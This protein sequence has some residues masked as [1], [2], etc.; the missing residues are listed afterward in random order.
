MSR[1]IKFRTW[2]PS[3]KKIRHF[4]NGMIIADGPDRYGM[5]FPVTEESVFLCDCEPMQFTGLL[6]KNGTEIY[7]GDIVQIIDIG[8]SG[9]SKVFFEDGM[10]CV[11]YWESNASLHEFV[12]ESRVYVIGNIFNNPE[13]LEDSQ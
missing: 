4:E 9:I 10:W 8:E 13:L 1:E 2:Y 3:V 6:D 11:N 7:E 12:T 5:F